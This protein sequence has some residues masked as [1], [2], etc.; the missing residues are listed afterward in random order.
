[1]PDT[2]SWRVAVPVCPITEHGRLRGRIGPLLGE[3]VLLLDPVAAAVATARR[4][5]A[6][7]HWAVMG[8][9]EPSPA[10]VRFMRELAQRP[11]LAELLGTSQK[12]LL[13]QVVEER[14]GAFIVREA[15]LPLLVG[16]AA[17]TPIVVGTTGLGGRLRPDTPASA[18]EEDRR[19][20]SGAGDDEPGTEDGPPE[21]AA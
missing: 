11:D 4:Y 14:R 8:T 12:R 2:P 17:L 1:M 6:E 3:W 21:A 13:T 7:G 10:A 15:A 16:L 9:V 20:D 5:L 19:S 18:G